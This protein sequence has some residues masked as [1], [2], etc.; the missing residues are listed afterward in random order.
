MKRH[1]KRGKIFWLYFAEREIGRYALHVFHVGKSAAKSLARYAVRK[2]RVNTVKSLRDSGL[3]AKRAHDPLLQQSVA[4]G[5]A[6]LIQ[7]IAKR[8]TAF[9]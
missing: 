4:H 8:R 2:Q 3:R 9:F 6:S 7:N 1:I 5:R